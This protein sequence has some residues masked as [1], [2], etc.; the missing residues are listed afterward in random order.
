MEFNSQGFSVVERTNT[1][2]QV[3]FN[4][5]Y[6]YMSQALGLSALTAYLASKEPLLNLFYTHSQSG[7][8]YSWIGWLA[9]LSPLFLVFYINS[10]SAIQNI[11]KTKIIFWSFSA[12]MGI[13]LANVFLLYTAASVFQA[14]LVTAGS[15][16]GL[17]LYA[18][19]TKRDL[20]GWGRFLYMGLI[21]LI[22]TSF[23]GIFL[24]SNFLS[25]G[26][27]LSSVIIFSGL[28]AYDTSRLKQMYQSGLS[29]ETLDGVAVRGALSLYLNFINMFWAILNLLG[30]RK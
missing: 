22:L 10:Q 1:D 21:G 6:S 5:I 25:T 12:L 28:T 20:S 27:S 16:L 30:D 23:V 15:F 17:S 7:L 19:S 3:Y 26:L 11:A 8:T 4:K 2:V 9:I 24:K 29:E 18:R 13:S 14:F